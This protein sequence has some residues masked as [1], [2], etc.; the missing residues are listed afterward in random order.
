MQVIIETHKKNG[1]LGNAY[2]FEGEHEEVF[3]E[4]RGVLKVLGIKTEQNPDI[5]SGVFENLGIDDARSITNLAGNRPFIGE[6]RFFFIFARAFTIEAQNALLK[7]FED[8]KE[9][10]HYFLVVPRRSVLLPTLMSRFVFVPRGEE[11]KSAGV[12]AKNFFSL[13]RTK[14]LKAI[15]V[16]VK[17]KDKAS[18]VEF[19]DALE[20]ES[21]SAHIKDKKWYTSLFDAKRYIGTRGASIKLILEGLALSA[22]TK[23]ISK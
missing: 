22:P 15:E 14:R 19:L 3:S 17:E 20:G 18:A 10:I 7:T 1:Q 4:L 13:S 12:L 8:A 2:L 6:D 9:G 21:Q 23:N 11:E 16:I 5:W